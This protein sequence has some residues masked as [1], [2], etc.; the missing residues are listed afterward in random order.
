MIPSDAAIEFEIA[1]AAVSARIDTFV[2]ALQFRQEVECVVLIRQE[3]EAFHYVESLWESMS[4]EERQPFLEEM[5]RIRCSLV[6]A[7]KSIEPLVIEIGLNNEVE[8][9]VV[10]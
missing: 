2:A 9:V 6:E 8:V 10:V 4:Q 1:L 3:V 5:E 7:Q